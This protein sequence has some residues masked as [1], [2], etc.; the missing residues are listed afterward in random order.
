MA[1][2]NYTT[3]IKVEKTLAE[4][5]ELLYKAGATAILTEFNQDLGIIE[6]VSF[7]INV[8]GAQVAFRMPCKWQA[9]LT[10]LN[11]NP[12]VPNR[13]KTNEQAIRVSWRILK[14]WLEAQ[15][16]IIQTQ[17][18]KPQEIFLPYAIMQNGQTMFE[19]VTENKLLLK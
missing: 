17:M 14:S 3:E 15:L 8:D 5:S 12:K 11:K 10:I 1:I 6:S 16:A 19:N 7:K 18:A 13:L 2:L 9:I 4:I